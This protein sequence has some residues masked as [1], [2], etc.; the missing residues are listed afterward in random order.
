MS[1]TSIVI[2]LT[3]LGVAVGIAIAVSE[4]G[5]NR[6]LT[7][8]RRYSIWPWVGLAGLAGWLAAY[9]L[10]RE[11]AYL[12]L[13]GLAFWTACAWL[14]RGWGCGTPGRALRRIV[15]RAR[16]PSA[17]RAVDA[18]TTRDRRSK[19]WPGG[20]TVT[21][22]SD[23]IEYLPTISHGRALPGGIGVRYTVHPARGST[24][25]ELRTLEARLAAALDVSEVVVDDRVKPSRGWLDVLW[26]DTLAATIEA[27]P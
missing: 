16:W 5:P 26:T 15:L 25:T 3:V 17:A 21:I 2:A 27:E 9:F 6:Y 22:G 4:Q 20:A 8:V 10:R 13:G 7:L 24:L 14:I 23:R 1:P 12:A 19:S 11:C 18:G